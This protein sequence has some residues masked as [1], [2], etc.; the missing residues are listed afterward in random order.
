VTRAALAAILPR[1]SRLDEDAISRF[2][3]I[4]RA[5][6]LVPHRL[7]GGATVAISGA[8]SV[9]RAGA[10]AGRVFAPAGSGEIDPAALCEAVGPEGLASAARGRWGD[11]IALARRAYAAGYRLAR[12]PFGDLPCFW[13]EVEDHVIA[14]TSI[15]LLEACLPH[16]PRIDWHRL[17]AFLLSPQ[18][19]N[20][21]TCLDGVREL[22]TGFVLDVGRGRAVVSPAW[23]PWDLAC[24][25]SPIDRLDDASEVVRTAIDQAI[26]A[27]CAN[28]EKPVLLLSGGLDSSAIAASLAHHRIQFSALT[29]V[30]RHR[31]GD[32][33]IYARAVAE[34]AGTALSECLRSTTHVDWDDPTPRRLARPSARIFRQPT[35][36]AAHRLARSTGSDTNI[37]GGGGDD[38]F[39]SLTSVVPLLDR[40]AVE[41]LS[42]GS[43]LTARDIA[44]R[45]DVGIPAVLG[46]AARRLVNRRVAFSWPTVRDFL[47]EG[48]LELSDEAIAHPWLDPPRRAL[49]GQAAHVALILDALGLSEDDSLDP[50]MR[51]IS[52]LVSQPVVEASL[53][54]RSWLWFKNGRNRAVIRHGFAGRLPP[55]VI[56]RTGK[57]TPGGFVSQIVEGHRAKLREVLLDGLLVA[58]GIADPVAVEAALA[59]RASPRDR[60]HGSLLAL[61]DAE[62]WARLWT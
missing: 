25:D 48:A 32:E 53:R 12:A 7:E 58:H 18:M 19:R 34:A 2:E 55:A 59:E 26:A 27:R 45:A 8:A 37:D 5:A 41:G 24:S 44:L 42:R 60:R 30:T 51:T 54:V 21:A 56:T 38:V 31:S 40:F 52:P 29:M 11:Y 16:R 33:R 6:G 9:G 61:V 22:T 15:T 57:G 35:L 4:S 20:G 62:R 49:P 10:I 28:P 23:S 1:T 50:A 36:Q 46:K 47:T 43:W 39:C 3:R 17:A 13:A 14:A